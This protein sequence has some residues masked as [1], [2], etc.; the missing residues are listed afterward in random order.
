MMQLFL[1]HGL[2]TS[3]VARVA[4]VAQMGHGWSSWRDFPA[5]GQQS[6]HVSPFFLPQNSWDVYWNKIQR[7]WCIMTI[8]VGCLIHRNGMSVVVQYLWW[9]N[10]EECVLPC[11]ADGEGVSVCFSDGCILQNGGQAI[12]E[13][14]VSCSLDFFWWFFCRKWVMPV[15][16]A[17]KLSS[18]LASWLMPHSAQG[19]WS[20]SRLCPQRWILMGILGSMRTFLG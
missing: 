20:T 16:L 19:H 10:W 8:P 5:A 7:C 15:P 3:T 1:K 14:D 11:S 18:W 9:V 12:W 17:E 13:L 4:H 6:P 2:P